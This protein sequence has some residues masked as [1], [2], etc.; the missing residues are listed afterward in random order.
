MR[1]SPQDRVAVVAPAS[2][3][4]GADHDLL[5]QAVSLLK[6]WDLIVDVRVEA[7]NHMYLAGPD[8][9]RAKHL[10]NALVDV[11]TK[12]IFCTRGGYG[13]S[14]L[15]RHLDS[16]LHPTPKI[17]VGFS[18]ITALHLAVATLWPHID[19]IHGPNVAT[20][21]L[22]D[23]S[24]DAKRN[25][26]ALH[27]A[28]FAEPYEIEEKV[29]F[30][31]GGDAS[32]PLVG[33]CLSLLSSLMGTEFSV[34]TAESILFVEDV[35]EL[36]FRIDRMLTQ[37]RNSGVMDGMKG[38]VFGEMRKCADPYNDVRDVILDALSG[39]SFPIGFGLRSGH[40]Y[41]N[42]ALRLGCRARLDSRMHAFVLNGD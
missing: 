24:S 41:T 9:M 39:T 29:E 12:A 14:R 21:Q 2:Q 30:L 10:H 18:D 16:T 6:S 40:G 31:R 13:S 19:L 20:K 25:R 42:I 36:P 27:Y 7:S 28:L 3:L 33:G 1:L 34:K 35:G 4:R 15:L 32:G 8:A 26:Q 23:D 5:E 38:M 11:D 37:L 17:L 22:L